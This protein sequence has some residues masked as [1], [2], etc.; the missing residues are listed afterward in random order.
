MSTAVNVFVIDAIVNLVPFVTG[1]LK[2]RSA[3]PKLSC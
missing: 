1:T 2:A 3:I